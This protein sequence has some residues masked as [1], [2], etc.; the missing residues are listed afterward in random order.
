M[1]YEIGKEFKLEAAHNL[2]HHEGKCQR[3][4]GHSYLFE[5]IV[6]AGELHQCGSNA[7]MV[8]DYDL[9]SK[10]GDWIAGELDHRNLNEVLDSDT[11]TAE[12]LSSTI[13]QLAKS[14][15]PGLVE[16][17]VK[18]TAK[19]YSSYR[20]SRLAERRLFK[21][22][23]RVADRIR[24]RLYRGIDVS[25]P[26]GCWL[27][28]GGKDEQGYGYMSETLAGSRKA[29]RVS[30]WLAGD[31]VEGKTVMHLCDNPSCVNPA[32]L[33]TGTHEENE[34]DKDAK[35]RRPVGEEHGRAK[36]TGQD[37]LTIVQRIE[38]GETRRGVAADYRISTALIDAILT[39]KVWR[40]VTK[41]TRP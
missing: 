9:L 22:G 26:E 27:F 16:V 13:F 29:H 24:R 11:T 18:E 14:R 21:I 34:A 25:D 4:H 7:G 2:V 37:V 1:S 19:T 30:A 10:V 15:L 40:H 23:E 31:D 39:G 36:L 20:P 12:Y 35:G 38:S 32:H 8:E 3:P 5:L 28:A 41:K 17:R 33:Y 6:E